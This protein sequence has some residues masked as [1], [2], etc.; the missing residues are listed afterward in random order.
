MNKKII[1]R[2]KYIQSTYKKKHINNDSNS[3]FVII[4]KFYFDEKFDD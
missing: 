1:I 3:N 4:E 2:I